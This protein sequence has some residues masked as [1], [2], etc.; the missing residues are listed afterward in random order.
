MKNN[1]KS[2]FIIILSIF[3]IFTQSI[4]TNADSLKLPDKNHELY[5]YDEVG[6]L[7]EDVKEYIINTNKELYNQTGAQIVVAVMNNLNDTDINTFSTKLFEKWK[8]GS[9]GKDNGILIVLD[10]E[11][12]NI[13]I[14][15]GYGLEGGIPDILV[16][17]TIE[18][19]II[20][21]FKNE[22]YNNGILLGFD[23][24]LGYVENEYDI[25]IEYR[26]DSDIIDDI[27]YV[28][29][30]SSSG[31]NILIILLIILILLFIDFRFFGGAVSNIMMRSSMNRRYY[32]GYSGYGRG[33]S[34]GGSSGSRGS[35][36]GGGRS[37]GGGAGG[38]W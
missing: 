13:W 27:G 19:S 30:S 9:K 11:N 36:G 22:E 21:S 3:L 7:N 38:S 33:G 17:R 12:R 16:K 31:K 15:V 8:I 24:L 10:Y 4:Y 18:E 29:S 6:I 14:E 2:I 5:I 37:G 32:G 20:P 1:K 23:R 28:S 25:D 26:E 35:S 34:Y